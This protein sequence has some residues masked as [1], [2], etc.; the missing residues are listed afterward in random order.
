MRRNVLLAILLALLGGALG[1]AVARLTGESPPPDAGAERKVLYWQAPMDPSYRSDKP[2]KSPMGMDLVPVYADEA[3]VKRVAELRIAPGVVNTIGVRTAAVE[4]GTLFRRVDTVGYVGVAEDGI[5]DIDVRLEGWIEDLRVRSEGET[6]R[7][8]DL[9][10]RIYSRP[11][12]SAQ[13]EYVQALRGGQSVM[14]AA[15]GERLRALGM[16]ETQIGELRSSGRVMERIG[17]HA[18]QDGFVASLNIR[19]GAYVRPGTPVMRLADLSTVWVLADVHEDRI[20]WI[21]EG[22]AARMTL[23][24]APGREWEGR[25]DYVY[26][27]IEPASR[28]ARVRLVFANPDGELRPAM[29][30]SIAIDAAPREH[31]LHIPREALIRTGRSE[32]VILALGEGR[33]RPA[34]VQ[35]GIESGDRVEILAG[36]AEG[37]RV[38]T[39]SQFLIDSEASLDASFL[40]M[41][42]DEQAGEHRHD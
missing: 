36:L 18:P 39:S 28:T 24:F 20:G 26:P 3:P 11:L 40:R 17:V 7:R 19:Q 9:L 1:Y 32:R 14:V 41:L 6:V 33:F 29:Y 22:Q 4:R 5:A 23:A 25:V 8:G 34:E 42:G 31:V 16:S 38:V 15:A 27:T 30:A 10:F 13:A 37:E 35:S 12:V 2:G 21:E